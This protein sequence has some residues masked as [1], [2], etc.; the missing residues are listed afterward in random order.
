VQVDEFAV[1]NP[2]N[3]PRLD[4]IFPRHFS[5]LGVPAEHPRKLLQTGLVAP[6]EVGEAPVAEQRRDVTILDEDGEQER[7]GGGHLPHQGG[8]QFLLHLLRFYGRRGEH[9]EEIFCLGNPAIDLPRNAVAEPHVELVVPDG[10]AA[11]GQIRNETI[12]K[13]WELV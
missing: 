2:R 7:A 12:Y 6:A 9:D 11:R 1:G 4:S 5:G 3:G 10:D 13:I 8:V